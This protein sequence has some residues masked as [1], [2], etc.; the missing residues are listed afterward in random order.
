M[1]WRRLFSSL[2]AIRPLERRVLDR[3]ARA[4]A[5]A[6]RERFEAQVARLTGAQHPAAVARSTSTISAGAGA[7]STSR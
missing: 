6:A 7:A 4:L 5:P 3:V 2:R 1:F